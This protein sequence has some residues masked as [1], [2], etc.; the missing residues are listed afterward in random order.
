M[1]PTAATTNEPVRNGGELSEDEVFEVLSNR[2]RRFVIHAL[3]RAEEPI[4]IS[5]LSTHVTA[6]ERGVDPGEVRYEDRRNVY[7]TLQRTHLPKLEEKNVVTVDEEANVV[8]PTP[9]LEGLDIYIEVLRS[10]EIP[11]SLYYVGLAGVAVSLL[12]AVAAGTPGFAG[13]EA[14]DVGV[15]TATAFGISAAAHHVIGRRARLG[16]TEKPPELRERR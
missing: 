8:E 1:V 13:L 3:K 15:F 14:L 16:N 10:R 9:E 11:W 7:S 12:L 4:D 6:W 2:R 5:E